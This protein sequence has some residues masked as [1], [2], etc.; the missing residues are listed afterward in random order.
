MIDPSL[1]ASA[2]ILT[3]ALAA[4]PAPPGPGAQ[5]ETTAADAAASAAQQP[6]SPT[7]MTPIAAG[8]RLYSATSSGFEESAQR[9]VS[10]RAQWESD[11]RQLHGGL[12]AGS[13]PPV[14]FAREAVVLVA[15]GTRNSGGHAVRIDGTS[16]SASDLIVHVT[17]VS[18]GASCMTTQEITQPAEAVRVRKPAGRVRVVT[19]AE[20]M[21]C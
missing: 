19:R 3:V 6:T 14:D 15:M 12:T 13:T 9:V 4:C 11:W 1:R 17:L 21:A 10:D 20:T 5:R 16:P 2:L 18:P 7:A 8:D